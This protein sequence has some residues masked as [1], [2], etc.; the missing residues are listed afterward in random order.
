[1]N[2]ALSY[3]NL[4][5]TAIDLSRRSLAYAQRKTEELGLSH[6][7]Y[8][9]ADI[10]ELGSWKQ[11]FDA[12]ECAGVLHHLQDPLKGLDILLSLLKPGGTMMIGLYSEIAREGI[13]K[14]RAEIAARGL[15]GSTSDIRAFRQEILANPDSDLSRELLWRGDFYTVSACRDMIFHVQEHRFTLP[16]IKQILADRHLKF[17][18]FNADSQKTKG[19]QETYPRHEDLTNLDL[20]HQYETKN[21]RTFANMYQFWVGKLS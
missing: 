6:I 18:A 9:Q 17:I 10:L 15:R 3:S 2:V 1:M 16:Q 5:V 4:Q 12:I 11:T 21:P 20:W 7:T 13:V 19:F 8:A 14:A